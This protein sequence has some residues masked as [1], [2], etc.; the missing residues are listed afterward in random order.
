MAI[1]FNEIPRTA[2]R[3]FIYVEIDS[4]RA[5]A[6]GTAFRSLLIGQSLAGTVAANTPY[7]VT[8]AEAAAVASGRGSILAG[9]VASFRRQAPLAEVW[10]IGLA[11][12][13]GATQRTFTVTVGAGATAA[14]AIALYVA[15]RRIEVGVAAGA[16]VATIATAIADGINA[17]TGLPATAGSAAGV[18]TITARNAGAAS[19][20]D[21][22]DSY[23]PDEALPA[24]VTLAIVAT[25]PGATDPD[26]TD[27]LDALGDEQYN[28]IASAYSGAT[29]MTALETELESALGSGPDK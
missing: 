28:V 22:R 13:G 16:A 12:A 17:Q 24:G 19:D 9:M 18:V 14:G 15:G 20:L 5:G 25:V 8:S 11:D 23:H 7:L 26:I 3:P 10:A 2:L 27:A 21:V 29:S 6:P 4:S 1:S